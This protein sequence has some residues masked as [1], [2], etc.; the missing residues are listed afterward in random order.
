M[1]LDPLIPDRLQI[2]SLA[3]YQMHSIFKITARYLACCR[4]AGAS[5]GF[6]DLELALR[7]SSHSANMKT[8][9]VEELPSI[10]RLDFGNSRCFPSL[11]ARLG[12]VSRQ[13][14]S[15]KNEIR[16]CG[17][18]MWYFVTIGTGRYN[19]IDRTKG[20]QR[21]AGSLWTTSLYG[22]ITA[23]SPNQSRPHPHHPHLRHLP[24]HRGPER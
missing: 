21:Q 22:L 24:T 14:I 16:V 17:N 20:L 5:A 23:S 18:R 11:K 4:R 10:F 8:C 1:V 19:D 13:S 7:S 3:A 9:R 15:G 12:K 6:P 2:L